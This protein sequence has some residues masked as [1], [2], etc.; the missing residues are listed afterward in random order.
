VR[1]ELP[2]PRRVILPHGQTYP[3]PACFIMTDIFPTTCVAQT[4]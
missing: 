3:A 1:Q 4:W 2:E